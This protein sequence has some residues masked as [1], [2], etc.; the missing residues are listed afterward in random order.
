MFIIHLKYKRLNRNRTPF[1]KFTLFIIFFSTIFLNTN[2]SLFSKEIGIS[3]AEFSLIPVNPK[4]IGISESACGLSGD[5]S[6]GFS[7]PSSISFLERRSISFSTLIYIE[8][9]YLLDFIYAA[10]T[11]DD[12]ISTFAIGFRAYRSLPQVINNY[13]GEPDL[14]RVDL[15]N[16][17]LF[18][19]YTYNLKEL[20]G[21]DLICGARIN[22]IREDF[23]DDNAVGA[24][25]DFGL[26]YKINT[27]SI[28]L[29]FLHLGPSLRSSKHNFML[30]MP[31]SANLG[32]GL[33]VFKIDKL[34]DIT[35]SSSA[36]LLFEDLKNEDTEDRLPKWSL[37]FEGK[38]LDIFSIRAGYVITGGTYKYTVG[39]GAWYD[40]GE[41]YLEL[42]YAFLPMNYGNYTH[43]IGIDFGF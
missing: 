27:L 13:Q 12:A 2:L 19:N 25:L 43:S 20:V 11:E 23:I 10:P 33:N 39:L 18:I 4:L 30:P 34:V 31:M 5:A 15:L 21:F 9:S 38:G 24:N 1:L 35:L 40:F 7:N 17:L 42:N 16:V 8:S 41:Y 26:L 29:S 28:G 3:A 22:L 36:N 32:L 6:Y 37:G 14:R